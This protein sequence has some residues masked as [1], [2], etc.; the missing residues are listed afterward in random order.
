MRKVIVN[1]CVKMKQLGF[2]RKIPKIYGFK[3]I[4]IIN[5]L[6]IFLYFVKYL[7]NFVCFY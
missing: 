3:F 5:Y 1:Q 6:N 7:I 4:L 2:F